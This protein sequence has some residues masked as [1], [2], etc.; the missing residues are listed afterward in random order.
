[1]W[2]QNTSV[3]FIFY[4]I[5][6]NVC[7]CVRECSGKALISESMDSPTILFFSLSLSVSVCAVTVHFDTV[8][9]YFTGGSHDSSHKNEVS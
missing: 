9:L 7:L 4:C 2:T 6:S 3:M 8:V 5:K 1:M